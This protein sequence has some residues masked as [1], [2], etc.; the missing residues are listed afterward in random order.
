MHLR[1]FWQEGNV[2]LKFT[3][4]LFLGLDS[5]TELGC[6]A[7]VDFNLYNPSLVKIPTS[8]GVVFCKIEHMG[9]HNPQ[10]LNPKAIKS[11][12]LLEVVIIIATFEEIIIIIF[13]NCL[14]PKGFGLKYMFLEIEHSF[15]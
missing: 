3:F 8:S 13:P 11:F 12:E 1:H 2:K 9:L 4:V 10:I 5:S 15:A 14:F 6:N 7:Y